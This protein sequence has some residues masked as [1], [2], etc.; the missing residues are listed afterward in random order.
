MKL[1]RDFS[2]IKQLLE[3]KCSPQSYL[4]AKQTN[5]QMLENSFKCLNNELFLNISQGVKITF[6]RAL[7]FNELS[8]KRNFQFIRIFAINL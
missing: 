8:E 2:L 6:Q 4:E 5:L 1:E 3:F 7:Q